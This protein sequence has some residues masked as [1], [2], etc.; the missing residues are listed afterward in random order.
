MGLFALLTVCIGA[1]LTGAG[2][3]DEPPPAR[4]LFRLAFSPSMFTEVNVDDA[5]AAMKVWMLAVARERD[6]PI[7]PEPKIYESLEEMA[8]TLQSGLLEGFAGTAEECWRLSKQIK[9]DRM[10]VAINANRMTE[11]YVLLVHRESGIAD[12]RELRG[13]RLLLLR[14]PRMSLATV[15]LDTLL[16]QKGL[17][18]TTRF[19]GAV[20]NVN[21]LSRAVLPV[22]FRQSDACL[23]TRRGFETMS[24]LNPQVGKLLRAVAVS[25]EVVPSG[26]AFRSDSTSPFRDQMLIEMGRLRDSPAGQQILTLIQADRIEEKPISCMAGAF[27]L[28]S[29]HQRLSSSM[30][31]GRGAGPVE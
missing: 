15:W 9:F 16:I 13:R 25:P 17:E 11:E 20:T 6:I 7:D 4:E 18:P 14:N 1:S 3:S 22:F 29:A 26:F 5:R 30:V 8:R 10:A 27:E 23:V 28:L 12:V 2:H 19:C 31:K 21:K 24:E